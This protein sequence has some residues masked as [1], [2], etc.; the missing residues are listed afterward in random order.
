MK[1]L[2]NAVKHFLAAALVVLGA[3]IFAVARHGAPDCLSWKI[4]VHANFV[5]TTSS[6]GSKHNI[7]P[8]QSNE[9]RQAPAYA[10]PPEQVKYAYEFSQPQF[11]IRHIVIEHDAT[12]RGK[13]TFERLNEE[14]AIV[15][16]VELSSA[17][18]GR[19]SALWENLRFLDSDSNYQSSKQFPHLGTMRLKMEQ[20]SRKRTAEF[21]WTN[22]N[23]VAALI[24]EYRRVADQ[25]VFIFDVSV[26][27]EN[28]PLNMPKLMEQL[29]M[30]LRRDS[31]SDPKQLVHLL[32]EITTDERVPLIA[33]NHA[34][35]LLK[36]IEKGKGKGIGE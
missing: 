13:I 11:Y 20:G 30:L 28:Q 35:R 23:D 2:P 9:T 4:D 8:I 34:I 19:I 29:E 3:A 27:R 22:D 26:A 17:A 32:Q 12:G 24:Q 6:P 10:L 1:F 18:L 15:E 16:P 33:R 5:Q 25:A 14:T 36:K 21:N 31:L 7:R